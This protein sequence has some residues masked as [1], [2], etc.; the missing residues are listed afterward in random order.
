VPLRPTHKLRLIA[1]LIPNNLDADI[2]FLGEK[3]TNYFVS[4]VVLAKEN[5]I[6]VEQNPYLKGEL[7]GD[8]YK[9]KQYPYT[10]DYKV[11][12]RLSVNDFIDKMNLHNT[13]RSKRGKK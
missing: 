7:D 1:D 4:R 3:H 8:S 5:E 13:V 12:H 9:A 10:Y 11:M 2:V 6:V